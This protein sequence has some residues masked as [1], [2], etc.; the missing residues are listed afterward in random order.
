MESVSIAPALIRRAVIGFAVAAG[1][2]LSASGAD[3]QPPGKVVRLGH[4]GHGV[5]PDLI[6]AFRQSL[7][8]LGYAE[9]RNIT[10]DYRFA[11]GSAEQLPKLAAELVQ[12]EVD[13]IVANGTPAVRAAQQA[14]KTIPVVMV[15]I[16]LDP[17]QLGLVRSLA[18][19]GG[20]VTG[21]AALGAEL[22]GKRLELFRQAVPRAARV[23]VLSNP[24]NPGN[25]LAVKEI[26]AVAPLAG[27]RLHQVAAAG[28]PELQAALDEIARQAP[29]ALIVVWDAFLQSHARRIADFALEQRLPTLV[30]IKEFVHAGA[31]MSYGTNIPDQWRRAAHYVEKILKGAKPADLPVEQPTKFDLVLN[32]KTARALKLELSKAL[33]LRADQVIE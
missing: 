6:Q 14:T 17:V 2:L 13:V 21:I 33:M 12:L 27:I 28:A 26:Q 9:G 10:V 4:L 25:V 8:D 1:L 15:G 30:P 11:K 32:L 5:D 23:A 19:P 16:G 29:E 18:R 31:L 20:N 3:A 22:W 7:Q 24:T